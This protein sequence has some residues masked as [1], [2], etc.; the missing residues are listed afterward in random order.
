M[1]DGQPRVMVELSSK[2]KTF[3]TIDAIAIAGDFALHGAIEPDDKTKGYR[4]A[5][6][7]F[8][9]THIATCRAVISCIDDRDYAEAILAALASVESL[10][11]GLCIIH[12]VMV[13]LGRYDEA[14]T[15][16]EKARWKR[17]YL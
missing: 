4:A 16:D 6:R 13:R 3:T 14:A 1:S 9:I 8:T 10:S 11:D 5:E 17:G 7:P 15:V 2:T 12:E